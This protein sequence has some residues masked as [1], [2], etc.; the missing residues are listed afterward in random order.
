MVTFCAYSAQ[1]KRDQSKHANLRAK[2]ISLV[3]WNNW[4]A[5]NETCVNWEGRHLFCSWPCGELTDKQWTSQTFGLRSCISHQYKLMI[6]RQCQS[7]GCLEKKDANLMAW[8]IMIGVVNWW[9]GCKFLSHGCHCLS[10]PSFIVPSV[11]PSSTLRFAEPRAL[12][13]LWRASV[14][15]L[16]P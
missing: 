4:I 7:E 15:L 2:G 12:P 9:F 10:S 6:C 5:F 11:Y 16:F 8:S 1:E 13:V 3:T 14:F